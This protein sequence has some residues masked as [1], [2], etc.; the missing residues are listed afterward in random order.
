MPFNF[1]QVVIA[2]NSRE[3][4]DSEIC[5]HQYNPLKNFLPILC[6][7]TALPNSTITQY[8]LSSKICGVMKNE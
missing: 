1:I 3:W 2:V 8:V 6:Y 5:S 7:D 4:L